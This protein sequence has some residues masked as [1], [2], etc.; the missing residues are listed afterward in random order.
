M[1]FPKVGN[2]V[3]QRDSSC[4]DKLNNTQKGMEIS[5]KCSQVQ[6]VGKLWSL[7]ILPDVC[8]PSLAIH[9]TNDESLCNLPQTLTEKNDM[10]QYIQNIFF[11]RARLNKII[12]YL[13]SIQEVL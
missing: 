11:L 1:I 13:F 3:T 9:F 4:A 10:H 2:W 5:R 8:R 6:R 12:I 7:H